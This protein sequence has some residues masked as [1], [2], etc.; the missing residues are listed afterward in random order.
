M[1]TAPQLPSVCRTEQLPGTA[2]GCCHCPTLLGPLSWIS[3]GQKG[4]TRSPSL[5]GPQPGAFLPPFLSPPQPV[6]VL[7]PVPV[8]VPVPARLHSPARPRCSFSRPILSLSPS[9]PVSVPIPNPVSCLSQAPTC[10]GLSRPRPVTRDWPGLSLFLS[11]PCP[12]CPRSCRPRSFRS[13][14]PVSTY[15]RAWPGVP[16]SPRCPPRPG[17]PRPAV[18]TCSARS[19]A[20]KSTRQAGHDTF[21]QPQRGAAAAS[22]SSGPG[23]DPADTGSASSASARARA[24]ASGGT[25]GHGGRGG[26]GARAPA[27]MAEGGAGLAR[28]RGR[29]PPFMDKG[30]GQGAMGG[31]KV[32]AGPAPGA[33]AESA[34]G[35]ASRGRDHQGRGPYANEGAG[36]RKAREARWEME[37]WGRRRSLGLLCPVYGHPLPPGRHWVHRARGC[38]PQLLPPPGSAVPA[39]EGPSPQPPEL[40]AVPTPRPARFCPAVPT[41]CPA[42]FC[43][44]ESPCRQGRSA[45]SSGAGGHGVSLLR[46]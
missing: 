46:P 35:V 9:P 43:P 17:T 31:T 7:V 26:S 3:R 2:P 23:G 16:V 20:P 14:V 25:G 44:A 1:G 45:G 11:R 39:A 24:R 32:G 21:R 28:G 18:P 19:S 40:R 29:A 41:P 13:G 5:S 34:G 22:C 37:S 33:M 15:P 12:R 38:H 42:R 36:S 6:P 8:P 10:P 30:A 4:P 27:A